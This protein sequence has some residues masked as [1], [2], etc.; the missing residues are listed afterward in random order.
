M[1]HLVTAKTLLDAW[2]RGA[3]HV[4]HNGPLLN[5][6]LEITSPNRLGGTRTLSKR[7]DEFLID[8]KEMPSHTVAE[9]IFPA[10]E[11]RRHGIEGVF[12]VY[13]EK[14]FPAIKGHPK[15]Q[16]GTYV[17]RL[18]RR[19]R[20][21]GQ[22]FNPLE[23][24][25]DAMR[26]ELNSNTGTKRSRYELGVLDLNFD[27]PIYDQSTDGSRCI[28]AP[29]LSHLSFKLF[30]DAVH[31]IAFYRSHDYSAKAYGNLLGLARLQACVADETGQKMGTLTVHSSYA[32]A[33]DH[34][35]ALRSCIKDLRRAL[36]DS[37]EDDVMAP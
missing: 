24:I 5:L 18:V 22:T 27:L 34:K 33:D 30:E 35:R 20:I 21:G 1:A 10:V 13:P 17:Y 9:T 31:L 7:I 12:S 25:L 29:C 23:C 16:W 15:V 26:Q 14:V 4:L 32:Y 28:G 8:A 2:I 6:T 37:G 11:Y 3:L 19:Q 36:N